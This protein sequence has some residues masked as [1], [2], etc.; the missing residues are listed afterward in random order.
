MGFLFFPLTATCSDM[1]TSRMD[2]T[3]IVPCWKKQYSQSS[4]S[5]TNLHKTEIYVNENS[6]SPNSCSA[7]PL[8]KC[9][10]SAFCSGKSKFLHK[11]P[12]FSLKTQLI[13][14]CSIYTLLETLVQLLTNTP[15]QP[16][17]FKLMSN[18]ILN[19]HSLQPRYDFD[20]S[21]VVG[22][23]DAT[24]L[25]FSPQIFLGFTGNGPKK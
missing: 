6:V 9:Q 13:H 19:N 17:C 8:W 2:I 25:G 24:L 7:K 11:Q 1:K 12:L 22:T 10:K 4:P 23:R 20:H 15:N 21:T 14:S 3:S 5:S 16:D 18:S